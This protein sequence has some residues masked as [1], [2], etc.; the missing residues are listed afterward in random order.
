[1]DEEGESFQSDPVGVKVQGCGG[2][3]AAGKRGLGAGGKG[4]G[5]DSV[6]EGGRPDC[7]LVEQ[8]AVDSFGADGT[9][10]LNLKEDILCSKTNFD[11]KNIKKS[12]LMLRPY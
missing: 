11:R 8:A 5:L 3:D 6:G 9:P 2:S 4:V 12:L 10:D 7:A 1:M